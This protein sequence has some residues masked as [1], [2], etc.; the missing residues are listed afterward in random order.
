MVVPTANIIISRRLA[1][2]D[3]DLQDAP[4]GEAAVIRACT[5]TKAALTSVIRP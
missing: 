3:M 1:F 2:S 4:R 5:E